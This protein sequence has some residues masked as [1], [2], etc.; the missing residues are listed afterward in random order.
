LF[1]KEDAHL[2]HITQHARVFKALYEKIGHKEGFD[3]VASSGGMNGA[4]LV[5][6]VIENGTWDGSLEKLDA[7]WDHLSTGSYADLIP[8][9]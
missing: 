2:E 3:I 8:G 1:F 5:R 9:S 7:F 6:H 4:I